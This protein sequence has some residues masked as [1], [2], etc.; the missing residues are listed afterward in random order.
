MWFVYICLLC[1]VD[2][3]PP[4]IFVE[5]F[6]VFVNNFPALEFPGANEIFHARSCSMPPVMQTKSAHLTLI[7]Y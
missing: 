4:V 3:W 2:P 5:P 6:N 1:K 7:N